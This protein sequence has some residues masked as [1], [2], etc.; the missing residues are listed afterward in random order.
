M[1]TQELWGRKKAFLV[2]LAFVCLSSGAAMAANKL[3]VKGTDGT[4]D[5]FVATDTGRLGVGT[6]S[7]EAGIH[8]KST[9][10]PEAVIKVEG[11]ESS[12]GGGFLGYT[13]RSTGTYFPRVNDRLGYFLFGTA[14]AGTNYNAGGVTVMAGGDWSATSTPVYF[15]F[16]TTDVNRVGNDYR[17]ERLRITASGNTEVY[18]GLRMT[19]NSGSPS[20]PTCA[21]N[22]RGT[23]W[24]TQGGTS[25]KD[26]VEVCTKDE[27]DNYDWRLIW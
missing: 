19:K 10:Y 16:L 14:L 2:A 17:F 27:F 21:S 22:S 25:E 7:P 6:N 13:K 11:T 3:I 20:K 5:K 1:N 4:T 8:I 15:S 18:G 9:T 23:I 26:K 24:Y 12:G